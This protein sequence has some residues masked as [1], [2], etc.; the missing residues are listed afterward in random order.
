MGPAARS[1]S[2]TS[3]LVAGLVACTN[4]PVSDSAIPALPPDIMLTD[5][6][7]DGQSYE[8]HAGCAKQE[9]LWQA[10]ILASRYPKLPSLQSGHGWRD[11]VDLAGSALSL[12]T[13]FDHISDQMPRNRLKVIHAY[14]SVAPVSYEADVDSPYTGLFGEPVV[15]GLA[16]LS[17]A[18]DP[19][20]I[21]FTPGMA[22]KL[23][24]DGRPS[25]NLHVMNSL[26]GQGSDQ[27][28][29]AHDFTNQIPRPSGAVLRLA[30]AYFAT[31]KPVPTQLS[32]DH[33]ARLGAEG[34]DVE[35]PSAPSQLFFVP[36]AGVATRSTT[37]EDFR[38]ELAGLPETTVLYEVWATAGDRDEPRHIGRVVTRGHFVASRWGDEGLFFRHNR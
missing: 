38:D 25:V 7:A 29:F 30:E 27:N 34:L 9:Y 11:F 1:A 14:G 23:F 15:C 16:R 36:G 26:N 37:T 4:A 8:S 13:S 28:F 20:R 12:N 2:L 33:V 3:L 6:K 32:V 5:T 17:L 21:G 35:S 22:L 19:K 31:A 24:V 10:G 18:G